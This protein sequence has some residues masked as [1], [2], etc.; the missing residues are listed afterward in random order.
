MKD[1]W[2]DA[3]VIS[4]EGALPFIHTYSVYSLST[5]IE[6]SLPGGIPLFQVPLFLKTKWIC[7]LPVNERR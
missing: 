4:R 5:G 7:Q 3:V 6:A 1:P 2:S